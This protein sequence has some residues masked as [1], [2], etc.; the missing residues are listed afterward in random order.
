M[1]VTG[2]DVRTFALSLPGTAEEFAWGM[3]IFKVSGRLFL[4][5]PENETSMAVRCPIIDRDELVQ[6]EPAKFWI[7]SH[8]AN[9]AW[10]RVHLSALDD[11]DELTAIITDSWTQAAPRAL[12]ESHESA[13]N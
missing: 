3:P 11:H 5:L 13:T 8:E 6:A 1:T 4:T 2:E 7:A 9:N 10:V 12:L